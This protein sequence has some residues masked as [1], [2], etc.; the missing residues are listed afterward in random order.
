[1]VGDQN[2]YNFIKNYA[3]GGKITGPGTGTSDS[4]LAKLSNGEFVVKESVTKQ[5][6]PFLNALNDGQIDPNVIRLLQ[7][8]NNNSAPVPAFRNGGVVGN[9]TVVYNNNTMPAFN[10]GG[11]VDRISGV[12][13]QPSASPT[14]EPQTRRTEARQGDT[15]TVNV[16]YNVT[17]SNG[18]SVEDNLRRTSVQQAKQIAAQIEKAKKN[19]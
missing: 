17:N 19:T 3:E 5:F 6:L 13:S 7:S 16:T 1:L 4:I 18:R 2:T 11:L 12:L 15:I 10:E 9:R 14:P 8:A